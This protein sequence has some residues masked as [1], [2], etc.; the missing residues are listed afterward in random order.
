MVM[1]SY[2]ILFKLFVN[3]RIPREEPG[4]TNEIFRE[5]K[6]GQF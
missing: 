4:A 2:L 5:S 1:A 3:L 6:I